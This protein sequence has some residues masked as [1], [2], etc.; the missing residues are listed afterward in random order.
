[1]HVNA[2][3][4]MI[5]VLLQLKRPDGSLICERRVCAVIGVRQDNVCARAAQPPRWRMTP[6]LAYRAIL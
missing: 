4:R 6:A 2:S 1:M 5:A 3:V